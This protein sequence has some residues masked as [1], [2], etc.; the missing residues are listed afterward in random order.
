MVRFALMNRRGGLARRYA[1]LRMVSA[2]PYD[3]GLRFGEAFPSRGDSR[4]SITC[5]QLSWLPQ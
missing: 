1:A 2:F 4:R 3:L 5:S